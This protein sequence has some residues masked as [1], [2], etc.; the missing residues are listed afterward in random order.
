MDSLE[1]RRSSCSGTPAATSGPMSWSLQSFV[2]VLPSCSKAAS[3]APKGWEPTSVWTGSVRAA[4]GICS[5]TCFADKALMRR[6]MVAFMDAKY[7]C[8]KALGSSYKEHTHFARWPHKC[9]YLVIV[10]R[11]VSNE[12]Q[13]TRH[14]SSREINIQ[15]TSATEWCACLLLLL[16]TRLFFLL[17]DPCSAHTVL[18][19]TGDARTKAKQQHIFL[20]KCVRRCH[21]TYTCLACSWKVSYIHV[22]Q[23]WYS[24]SEAQGLT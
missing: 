5:A 22:M 4:S 20:Y 19:H 18:R 10:C 13:K 16:N 1:Y 23:F 9:G 2:K 7:A 21:M 14:L 3:S 17:F 15:M 6:N 8:S 12:K 24:C 11:N